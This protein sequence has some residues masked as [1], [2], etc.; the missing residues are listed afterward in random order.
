MKTL[1]LTRN[2]IIE[3]AVKTA[4]TEARATL[5]RQHGQVWTTGEATET[6]T[7]IAFCAPLA[8]VRKKI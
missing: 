3:K 8:I 7:F 5:E 4:D 1:V 2:D 6:F